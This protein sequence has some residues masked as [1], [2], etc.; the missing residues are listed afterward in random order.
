ML[1][2][3]IRVHVYLGTA[4]VHM[5]NSSHKL[6]L[7][8][9][10]VALTCLDGA[11]VT[12]A[13]GKA[14]WEPA[15]RLTCHFCRLELVHLAGKGFRL[16]MGQKSHEALRGFVQTTAA[17]TQ[18][19]CTAREL[20]P[21]DEHTC[22]LCAEGCSEAATLRHSRLH[23]ARKSSRRPQGP[24]GDSMVTACPN[25][26]GITAAIKSVEQVPGTRKDSGPIVGRE[27]PYLAVE[28]E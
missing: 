20:Q 19:T 14:S 2:L 6:G 4:A 7:L 18:Q 21:L 9:D 24:T 26:V 27:V 5:R 16:Q 8:D 17:R 12:R 23:A 1:I 10:L 13:W 25:L 11:K 15:Q 3:L 22:G 28:V